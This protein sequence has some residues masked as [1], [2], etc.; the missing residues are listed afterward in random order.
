MGMRRCEDGDEESNV[1][2]L[3]YSLLPP[4]KFLSMACIATLSLFISS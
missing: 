1:L 4:F 3:D 2:L